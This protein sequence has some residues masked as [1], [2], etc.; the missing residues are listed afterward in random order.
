MCVVFSGRALVWIDC[1]G[2]VRLDLGWEVEE[3]TLG[4]A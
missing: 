3:G 2:W 1:V 4:L